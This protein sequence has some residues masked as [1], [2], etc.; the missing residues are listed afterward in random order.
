MP[1][2]LLELMIA[3]LLVF[4]DIRFLSFYTSGSK[5]CDKEF[6][7]EYEYK[8]YWDEAEYGKCKYISPL[9]KLMLTKKT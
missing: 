1:D 5:S 3:K 2:G 9:S 8:K 4:S 6:L 7:A